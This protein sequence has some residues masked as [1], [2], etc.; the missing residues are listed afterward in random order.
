VETAEPLIAGRKPQDL[1]RAIDEAVR[2]GEAR[3]GWELA[4]EAVTSGID[5]ARFFTYACYHYLARQQFDLA[6][7]RAL[8]AEKRAPDNAEAHNALGLSYW[9]LGRE[10]D[11]LASFDRAIALNPKFSEPQ[12]SR[13]CLLEEK[14]DIAGAVRAYE[15]A[16]KLSNKAEPFA[17]LASLAVSQ[18][19][20]AAAKKHAQRTLWLAPHH[21][22]GLLAMAAVEIDEQRYAQ[23]ERRLSPLIDS[24]VLAPMQQ[25]M[26]L[27]LMGDLFDA[28]ARPDQA[29][30][31]Y[32]A[33]KQV[34]HSLTAPQGPLLESPW[35]RL[36]RME[37]F[38]RALPKESFPKGGAISSPVSKHVFVLSFPRSGTTL[39]EQVLKGHPDVEAM[40]E[41]DCFSSAIA[42]FIEPADGLEHLLA[43]SDAGL[44]RYRD[45]YW[46]RA[47]EHGAAADRPVFVD[48][49]PFNSI[50]LPVIARLFP[51]AIILFAVR[52]PRDVVFSCFR[53]RIMMYELASLDGIARYYDGVMGLSEAYR[54]ALPLPI[55]DVRHEA[56]LAD[57]DGEVSRICKLIGIERHADMASFAERMKSAPINTPSAPQIRG[58]LNARSGGQWRRYR[59]H[60][61]DVLAILQPWVERF[62]YSAD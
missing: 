25:A 1:I 4:E 34:F 18:G 6:L 16:A 52:D 38:F 31:A 60:L 61:A 15:E 24:S 35:E 41:K 56:L 36:D 62:G 43:A 2:T 7:E 17:H 27:G 55:H 5:E 22:V 20:L 51:Q 40:E 29:F 12:F 10:S 49:Q 57:F 32:R 23:A 13:G 21:P 48:K 44:N 47:R 37:R 3:A 33:C 54:A 50:L 45:E 14:G 42:D 58:G 26:A 59:G 30:A 39:L 53:R 46:R 11:A 28:T 9:R 8:S 19:D